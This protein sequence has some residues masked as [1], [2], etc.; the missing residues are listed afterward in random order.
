MKEDA[1]RKTD[2]LARQKEEG[3]RGVTKGN[4]EVNGDIIESRTKD[5]ECGGLSYIQS[6]ELPP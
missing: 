3:P 1:E 6:S 2:S 5:M 4:N